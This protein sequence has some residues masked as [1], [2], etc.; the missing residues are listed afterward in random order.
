MLLK[1]DVKQD[2]NIAAIHLCAPIF[3]KASIL[4][5]LAVLARSAWQPKIFF[6]SIYS[7]GGRSTDLKCLDPQTLNVVGY[8]LCT[9]VRTPSCDSKDRFKQAKDAS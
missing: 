1:L 2:P 8:P 6:S 4:Q 3:V 5:V 7:V 9:K